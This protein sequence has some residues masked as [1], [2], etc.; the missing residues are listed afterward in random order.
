MRSAAL[1]S[2][3]SSGSAA[4]SSR[5]IRLSLIAISLR[6]R[7]SRED[8]RVLAQRLVDHPLALLDPLGD[9]HLA[10][11]VEEGDGAHLA[12]VHA[13]RVVGLLVG[14]ETE[15][16]RLVLLL[17]ELVGAGLEVVAVLVALGAVDDVDAEVGEPEI[18]LVQLVGEADHL[19]RQHLVDLVVQEV[20]LLLAQLDELLDRAV[21]LFDVA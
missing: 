2:S 9:L 5:R 12:Q 4:T 18:D 1:G 21:L 7:S 19:F 15:F 17:V 8:H 16:R 3:G 14:G 10:L 11:A 20:A 6:R 13:H